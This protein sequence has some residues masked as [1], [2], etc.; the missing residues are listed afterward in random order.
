LVNIVVAV[1]VRSDFE[2]FIGRPFCRPVRS[3]Y[4]GRSASAGPDHLP[5]SVTST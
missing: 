2:T 4:A 5:L 1:T 3:I